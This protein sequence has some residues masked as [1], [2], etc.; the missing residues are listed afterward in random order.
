MS[1][2]DGVTAL[3]LVLALTPGAPSASDS[4]AEYRASIEKWRK[5]REERLKSPDGWLAVAGFFWLKQGENGFG[6]ADGNAIVLPK[7]AAPPRAGVFE[8]R[9]RRTTVRL[10]PGVEASV[11]G[12][13]VTKRELRPDNP[14]P[15]DI[16]Q[17][18]R[19][20][21]QVIERDKRYAIRLRDPESEGRRSFKGLEW[22]P[23][24]EEY[25]VTARFLPFAAPKTLLVPTILDYAEE[26]KS[27]G[28][29]EFE[30]RGRTLRLQAVYEGREEKQLFFIFRDETARK[31]TYGA[32]R[33]LY[34]DLPK[35]G[36]VVL[37][38]N[39]AYSPPCAYT[40]YA[41]CP[42]PPKQNRMN[43]RIEAGERFSGHH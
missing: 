40:D 20:R 21:M 34:A 29:V 30:L 36:T 33:F 7:G 41:T 16:L 2:L 19:L 35:D 43:V 12:E 6:S 10:E 26:Y 1:R 38:F 24:R 9:G 42:L 11:S 25:R 8:H 22:F 37:D 32:G 4:A 5:E 18:G 15:A 31:E 3:W 27:P 39:K 13:P 14:G 17:L 23:I 28:Q